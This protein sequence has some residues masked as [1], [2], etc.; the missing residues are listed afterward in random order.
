M[1]IFAPSMIVKLLKA[2]ISDDEFT[3]TKISHSLQHAQ[4]VS[5]EKIKEV[6]NSYAPE[7]EEL[8]NRM[9]EADSTISD[10][11]LECM[12]E[13]N[14][15]NDEEDMEISAIEEE[16]NEFQSKYDQQKETVETQLTAERADLESFE[17]VRD[18][19]VK[20]EFDVFGS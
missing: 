19:N 6:Q 5:S 12:M 18:E 13:L 14:E 17:Q 15:L 1:S 20:D 11:Y 4:K 8:R 16:A 10:E 7:K 2:A 3:L 9:K